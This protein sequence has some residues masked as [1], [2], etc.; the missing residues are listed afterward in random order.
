MGR[1]GRRKEKM[2]RK[3]GK[4]RGKESLKL[5]T[6]FITEWGYRKKKIENLVF[7]YL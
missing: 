7:E 3:E 2:N 4:R 6:M 5:N 1:K